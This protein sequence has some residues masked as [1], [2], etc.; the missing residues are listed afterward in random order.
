MKNILKNATLMAQRV[1]PREEEC[2]L[3]VRGTLTNTIGSIREF[4]LICAIGLAGFGQMTDQLVFGWLIFCTTPSW[5]AIRSSIYSNL[6]YTNTIECLI[7]F[8]FFERDGDI[9]FVHGRRYMEFSQEILPHIKHKVILISHNYDDPKAP[10]MVPI[11]NNP[12]VLHWFARNVHIDHP[13]LTPIPIGVTRF[14]ISIMGKLKDQSL[15]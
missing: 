11:L 2:N 6:P 8:F 10:H 12:N 13:K 7:S 5:S 14:F 4:C 15:R 3:K 1:N 9:I